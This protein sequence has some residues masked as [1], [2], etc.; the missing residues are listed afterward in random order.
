MAENAAKSFA[1]D[2]LRHGGGSLSLLDHGASGKRLFLC[3]RLLGPGSVQNFEEIS[4]LSP[5]AL[6]DIC[7][8]R[9]DRYDMAFHIKRG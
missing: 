5:H 1:L 6:V 8:Q 9:N 7:L 4:C 2:I 3:L